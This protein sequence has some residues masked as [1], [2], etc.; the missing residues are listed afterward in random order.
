[1]FA[2]FARFIAP[3]GMPAPVLWGDEDVV[4]ERFGSAVSDL[5]LTHVTYRFTYPFAPAEVVELFRA[6]YGPT[7]R[8]FAALGR[9]EQ[10]ALRADLVAL[11]ADANVSPDPSRTEVE[12]DYL[13]VVGVRR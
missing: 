2:I 9:P 5:A 3:P 10:D 11:W 1:M 12:A 4:R 7:T 6:Y 8:A 13:Q